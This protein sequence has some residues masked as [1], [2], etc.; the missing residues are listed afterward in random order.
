[1]TTF[2]LAALALLA[3]FATLAACA[4]DSAMKPSAGARDSAMKPRESAASPPA[5]IHYF[6]NLGAYTRPISSRNAQAQRWFDQGMRL[7]YGFN[8]EAAGRS[9]AQAAKLDPACAICW[10]GQALV[11]GPNVNLKMQDEAIAPAY[12]LSRKALSLVAHASP[13]EGA[14]IEALVLRYADPQPAD[15]S[16]LD[17]AYA[18]AMGQVVAKYPDDPDA[19]T[20][21]AEALMDLSPWAY[22]TKTGDPS[23]PNTTILVAQL[24]AVLARNPDHIG[25]IHYYVH[26]TESSSRPEAAEPHADRL[27]MLSP[28]S[29]HLV[30]MPSHTY[31]RVG[32]YHDATLI[33]LKATDAD[34]HFLQ[35]CRGSNGVYPLGYV[36]HNWHFIV[37]TAGLEGNAARAIHAADQTA[38]RALDKPY[39]DAPLEFMQQFLVAPLL[40]RV[41][42]E[43]WNELLAIE[44][45]PSPLPYPTAIWH[46]ARGRAHAAKGA[47]GGAGRDL[48][49]LEALAADR[50]VAKVNFQDVNR[51]D[52]VLEVAVASLRGELAL[53]RGDRDAGLAAMRDAVAAEDALNYI[54]PPEWPLQNRHRLGAEL[55]AANRGAEAEAVF[56]ADLVVFP[57]NGWSLR[58]LADALAAQGRPAEAEATNTE[59]L[60]AWKWA[61][62]GIAAA[63]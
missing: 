17:Q 49:A 60:E 48:A 30:H 18:T 11:L 27:A 40:A 1:M 47:F 19:A 52:A 45:P 13:A 53:A 42:F 16:A 23:S 51:A 28:G 12:A 32:R 5:L 14:L 26:A 50:A 44:A 10:W 29:G 59:F 55:L 33:N 20:L 35:F 39:Q 7:T 54:E 57:K 6:D 62:T 4:R 43:R 31:I 15:R 24:E 34:K 38:V 61:D 21:Y 46:Y 36:P 3:A 41:R 9:F 37:T 22:W 25:A 8:H 2:R 56:R 58:G 63:D